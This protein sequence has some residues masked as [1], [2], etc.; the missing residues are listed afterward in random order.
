MQEPAVT[1]TKKNNQLLF[2]KIWGKANW[3]ITIICTSIVFGYIVG[4]FY[5][6]NNQKPTTENISQTDSSQS[7]TFTLKKYNN[8]YQTFIFEIYDLIRANYWSEISEEELGELYSL[9]YTKITKQAADP[10]STSRKDI[11]KILL[12]Q[13]ENYNTNEEKETFC[14]QLS[15]LV[16]TNLQPLNRSKLYTNQDRT[17]LHNEVSNI[18]P[19]VNHFNTLG[20]SEEVNQEEVDKA[21]STKKASLVATNTS[22]A[23]QELQNLEKSYEVLNNKENRKQYKLNGVE[24]TMAYRLL[25]D[26]TFYL[27]IKKFSPTTVDELTRTLKKLEEHA[28]TNTLILDLRDNIGGAIDGLPYFLGPFIGYDQYAYQFFQQNETEDF[29]TKTNQLE[30]LKKIKKVVILINQNTQSSAEVMASV[31]KQYNFGILLGTTTRGWGTVERIFPLES[32]ISQNEEHA[33]FLVHHLTLRNDH[34]PIEGNG[35]SP[36]IKITNPDWKKELFNTYNDQ[37]L[38]NEIKLLY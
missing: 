30:I 14:I 11:E 26:R 23:K 6:D 34:L 20:I 12:K 15:Q 17:K 10:S 28:Q 16:I 21:Y 5:L 37:E 31:L 24:P 4:L 35:V 22:E 36:D 8:K 18:N 13:I 33:V 2:K 19:E 32:Q 27:Q 9:A 29:K 38:I 7:N 3:L 1:K 25:N